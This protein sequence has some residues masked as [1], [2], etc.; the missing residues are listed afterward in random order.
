M[1]DFNNIYVKHRGKEISIA[2]H[3]DNDG[4]TWIQEAAILPATSDMCIVRYGNS[5]T[6]L[7]RALQEIRDE[8]DKT[9]IHKSRSKGNATGTQ[10]T[11]DS[12]T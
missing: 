1:M 9:H 3:K 5:L 7:I 8:I 6:S 4:K 2:Q 11:A 10:V 12:A